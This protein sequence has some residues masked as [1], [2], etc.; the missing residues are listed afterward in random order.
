[1]DTASPQTQTNKEKQEEKINS[2]LT[3]SNMY[4][5]DHILTERELIASHN[6]ELKRK[7]GKRRLK[8]KITWKFLANETEK[9][10][11][12]GIDADFSIETEFQAKGKCRRLSSFVGLTDRGNETAKHRWQSYKIGKT[13]NKKLGMDEWDFEEWETYQ[14]RSPRIAT[15]LRKFKTPNYS[16]C[17]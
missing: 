7:Y 10:D 17:D 8:N 2:K 9:D 12:M 13:D 16:D 6:K 15:L 4:D 5:D 14:R 11:E 1:V 3:P